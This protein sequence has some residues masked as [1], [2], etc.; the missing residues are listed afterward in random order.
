MAVERASSTDR[1]K[2]FNECEAHAKADS[3]Y[4]FRKHGITSPAAA[5][6]NSKRRRGSRATNSSTVCRLNCSNEQRPLIKRAFELPR[7]KASFWDAWA[8]QTGWQRPRGVRPD[9]IGRAPFSLIRSEASLRG[10]S[11]S[12]CFEPDCS[13][14]RRA[15]RSGW[16]SKG[17]RRLCR[18]LPRRS[19]GG[20]CRA[21]ACGR[22]R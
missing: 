5:S 16:S 22:V 8:D 18:L 4:F 1:R 13:T 20:G 2:E 9:E 19:A 11:R 12:G 10:S 14:G 7:L 17:R 15:L 3:V 21:R 6:M